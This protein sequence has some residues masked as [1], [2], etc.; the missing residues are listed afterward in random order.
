MCSTITSFPALTLETMSL[1]THS[2]KLSVPRS[3]SCF[4]NSSTGQTIQSLGDLAAAVTTFVNRL[5]VSL[6]LVIPVPP[7]SIRNRQ[8]IIILAEAISEQ[9]AIPLAT[10]AVEKIKHTPQM[11]DIP[12][13]SERQSILKDAFRVNRDVVS[14]QSVL[15]F[16]DLFDS[17]AT[18][19]TIAENLFRVGHADKVY[20]LAITR[21]GSR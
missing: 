3:V 2:L 21:T 12:E 13:H 6:S 8:P 19:N 7:S 11:K 17:G 16:D 10:D 18:M 1:D 9:L 5:N 14:G 20:A 4:T 15:L